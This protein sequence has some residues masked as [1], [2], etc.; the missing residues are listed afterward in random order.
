MIDVLLIVLV[1]VT[2]AS[3]GQIHM[4]K[5]LKNVGGIELRDILSA[6]LFST[7]FERNVFFGLL[8]Y[9]IATFLWLTALSKAEVSFLYPLVAI[10]YIVTAFLARLYFK[11]SITLMRWFGISLIIGGVF[12]IMRS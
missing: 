12:L 11:E 8:L 2:M 9:V 7:L 3:F 10:G 4:K 1:C 5:G 6:K